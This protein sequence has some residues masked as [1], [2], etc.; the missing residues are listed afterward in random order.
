MRQ[1]VVVLLPNPAA[2][3]KVCDLRDVLVVHQDVP[4]GNVAVH[5][6]L[7]RQVLETDG[8]V[9]RERQHLTHR[10]ARSTVVRLVLL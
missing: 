10:E 7:L 6:V 4:C 1:L 3:A 2:K 5:E 8:R 9:S